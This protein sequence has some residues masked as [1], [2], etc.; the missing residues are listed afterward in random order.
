MCK[1]CNRKLKA[2]TLNYKKVIITAMY[3]I[4]MLIANLLFICEMER[5]VTAIRAI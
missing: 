2:S 3:V 1:F 4:G 5:P